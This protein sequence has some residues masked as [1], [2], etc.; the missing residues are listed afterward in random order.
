M[1]RQT[2]VLVTGATGNVG[3][4]VVS[5]LLAAGVAVRA[6]V[7]NL[8]S[9]DLPEGVEVVGGDLSKPETLGTGLDEV[10]AVFLV[11]PFLT[12][13]GAPAVVE[14][15][16]WHA[17]RVVYLSSED[18]RDGLERQPDPIN[19][20][21]ADIERLIEDSGLEWTFLR[22]GGLATNALAWAE[23]IRSGNVVREPFGSAARSPI[24]ERDIA[25]VAVRALTEDG[26]I[27]ARY[28]LTGPQVLTQAEQ[29]R[30]NGEAINRPLRH[31]EIPPETARAE[32]IAE[33]WPA[34]VVDG[35]LDAHARMVARPERVT[36]TVEEITG[37]PARTFREWATDHAGDFRGVP[38]SGDATTDHGR[39][40]DA[41][42]KQTKKGHEETMSSWAYI[43]GQ[44]GAD[45]VADRFAIE[46]AGQRTTLVPVPDESEAAEVAV[47]LIEEG[48]ELIELC[49]GFGVTEAARVVEAVG[50]RVPV[51]HV[52][53]GLESVEGAAAYKA[54][55]EA[56]S[57]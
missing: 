10:G 3:R 17:R 42:K 28:V 24:H 2:K 13:E 48:V 35:I 15:I 45:P 47:G 1:T 49:G 53:F 54:R 51:G 18:V 5:R 4:E 34:S 46:R 23:Q 20:L 56:R 21:H 19:Q 57:S 26:H 30:T 12:A 11:W 14:A 39:D 25:A 55:F 27:G 7:R 36:S 38:D 16:A 32:W 40:P 33:G 43:Y 41:I 8:D 29:V 6:L 44:P 31:K 9:V 37:S 50:G 22:S 52:N